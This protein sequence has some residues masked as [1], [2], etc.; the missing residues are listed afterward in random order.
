MAMLF[1]VVNLT[2]DLV[3]TFVDPR[4]GMEE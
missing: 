4:V 1:V 2:I 3:L